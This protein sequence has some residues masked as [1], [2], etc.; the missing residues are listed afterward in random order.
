M[1]KEEFDLLKEEALV[2][3]EIVK[4]YPEALQEQIFT[5]FVS[6]LLD[7]QVPKPLP[8]SVNGDSPTENPSAFP[9]EERNVVEE[10]KNFVEQKDPNGKL[11]DA[12]F[13]P[14]VAYF[15]TRLAPKDSL[16]E[17]MNKETLEEACTHADRKPPKNLTSTLSK[18]K[19]ARY[20]KT[21]S[22]RGLFVLAA[23]GEHFVKS[24]PKK[25]SK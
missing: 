12:Q 25:D 14:L 20:L 23:G 15:Y 22:D 5:L 3:A 21:G 10:F 13:V 18:A 11:N 1:S 7:R 4:Q 19:A 9:D 24:L 16:I 2:I 6:T 8:P 17:E